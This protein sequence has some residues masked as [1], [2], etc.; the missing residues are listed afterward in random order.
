[1][2]GGQAYDATLAVVAMVAAWE[3]CRMLLKRGYGPS[4]IFALAMAG[5]LAIAPALSH[6]LTWWKGTLLIGSMASGLWFLFSARRHDAFLDWTLTTA[7][8]LYTGGL[9]GSLVAIRGSANGLRLV[10]LVLIL[11][12]AYDTGAYLVGRPLGRTPFMNHIS[13]S[14]TWEGVA[15]GVAL[16]LFAALAATGPAR[17]SI[18]TS[19]VVGIA[20]AVAAQVGDLVESSMK[21]H[22][23]V[24]DSGSLIP[25][26]GGLLDRIDSL[27]FSSTAAY[28]VFMVMGFH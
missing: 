6:A 28:Y 4:F 7:V 1:L 21:R 27:L 8:A 3:A 16:T 25:G 26:H 12:W 5:I 2:I 18:L 15:G 23:E 14:K 20:I 24:K 11:N 9:L 22:C 19:V 10:L 17:V 13:Q